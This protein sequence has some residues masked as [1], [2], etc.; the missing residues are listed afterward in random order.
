MRPAALIPPA[1]KPGLIRGKNGNAPLIDPVQDQ[2]RQIVGPG[3][4][5]L[6]GHL[7]DLD[8]PEPAAPAAFGGQGLKPLG[9]RMAMAKLGQLENALASHDLSAIEAL[10]TELVSGYK[11]SSENDDASETDSGFRSAQERRLYH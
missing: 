3:H 10:L 9:H 5:H 11:P 8:Q 2:K 1:P 4:Q 6:P 7:F